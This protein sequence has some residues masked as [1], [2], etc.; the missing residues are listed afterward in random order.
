[1]K[2]SALLAEVRGFNPKTGTVT[3]MASTEAVDRHGEIVE[4]KAF[5]DDAL[6]VYRKNPVI[7]AGHVHALPDGGVPVIGKA[8]RV[9]RH[10][11][12][13]LEIEVEFAPAE[14]TPLGPAYRK[15]YELGFLKAFSIGFIPVETERGSVDAP[16]RHTKVDLLEISAVSVPSN[17]EALSRAADG[18]GVEARFAAMM[19]SA[20]LAPAAPQDEPEHVWGLDTAAL[21]ASLAAADAELRGWLGLVV[22]TTAPVQTMFTAAQVRSAAPTPKSDPLARTFTQ[23]LTGDGDTFIAIGPTVLSDALQQHAYRVVSTMSG[24]VFERMKPKTDDLYLFKNSAMER[25]LKEVDDFW[26]VAEDYA[27]LG[28]LHHRG[29]LLEG[30]PGTGKTSLLHQVAAMVVARG[31][32][33]FFADSISALTEGLRRFRDVEPERRV[34]VMI[35]DMDEH[36][37]YEQHD[38]LQLLDGE[39]T[40]E[41]VLYLATTN[42][43]ERF[44]QRLIRPGRFDR[45]V[46]VGPPPYEGRLAYLTHKLAKVEQAAEIARLAKRTDGFSF[47]HLRE[48]VLAVYA[49]KEPVEAALARL[50]GDARATAGREE[51][52]A[53]WL[54]RTLADLASEPAPTERSPAANSTNSEQ[55]G[56]GAARN[57]TTEEDDENVYLTLA[58]LSAYV[59]DSLRDLELQGGEQP[60][61]ATIGILQDDADQ[62]DMAKPRITV[63]TFPKASGWTAAT[64]QDW[65]GRTDIEALLMQALA[66]EQADEMGSD[67]EP[68]TEAAVRIEAAAT[69]IEASLAGFE[70]RLARMERTV[71]EDAAQTRTAA[72]ID[73]PGVRDD[74]GHYARMLADLDATASLARGQDGNNGR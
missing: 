32:V 68:M 35:E 41:G 7:L 74:D 6:A 45:I 3:A 65:L 2:P 54:T 9:D 58:P 25:V 40:F 4:A 52:S 23:Y 47:G 46:H 33:V 37:G 51:R 14:V 64:A 5:T 71:R 34:M 30:P 17:R 13:G 69:R 57:V 8:L 60:V 24:V 21:A 36:L 50:T 49:L 44:P 29:I 22:A 72:D 66:A 18:T 19:K 31:D 26:N 38:V 27:K 67:E 1:M 11:G 28:V 59:P 62:P 73:I 16:M 39:Q 53:A 70:A 20:V 15:G 42:F 63:L 48:L 56:A 55:A 43:L 10:D 12:Q 61:I